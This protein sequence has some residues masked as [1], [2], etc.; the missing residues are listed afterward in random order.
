MRH[1]SSIAALRG[2]SK[3]LLVDDGTQCQ[4]SWQARIY[5]LIYMRM[6]LQNG[7]LEC[8]CIDIP[9]APLNVMSYDGL[10]TAVLVT[11]KQVCSQE[12]A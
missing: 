7:L 5:R 11:A 2:I 9:E 3:A 1:F 10:V 6:L 4:A 12:L 8:L